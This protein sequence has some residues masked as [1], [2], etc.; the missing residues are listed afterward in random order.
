V[1]A[2]VSLRRWI[3]SCLI[4]GLKYKLLVLPIVAL[5]LFLSLVFGPRHPAW[6]VLPPFAI[7]WL[8]FIA[9]RGWRLMKSSAMRSDRSFDRKGKFAL[10]DEYHNTESATATKLRKRRG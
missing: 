10:A 7:L 4:E 8:G 6:I 3:D 2:Y 1:S 9:W 5:G